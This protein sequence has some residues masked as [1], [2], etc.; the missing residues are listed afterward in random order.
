MSMALVALGIDVLLPALPDIR[1]EYGL[2][3]DSTAVAALITVYV[4]GLALGQ[5]VYGPLSDRYGR[6]PLLYAGYAGGVALVRPE[7][8]PALPVS[9]RGEKPGQLLWQVLVVMVPP[10]VLILLVL[11]SIFAGIAAP[12]EAGALGAVG[13][14]VLAKLNGRLSRA[15][16]RGTVDETAKLT[17]MVVFILIGSTAFALTVSI[18]VIVSTRYA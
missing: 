11:G 17:S 8:A 16:L 9:E 7:A 1:A 12:T 4:I 18:A 6:K 14:I 13:A 2:D 15:S 3:P 10:L 5:L